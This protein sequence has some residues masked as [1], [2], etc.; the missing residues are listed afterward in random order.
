MRIA[1]TKTPRSGPKKG[2]ISDF[3]TD[4]YRKRLREALKGDPSAAQELLM[5]FAD[6][7]AAGKRPC[8]ETLIYLGVAARRIVLDGWKP[9]KALGLARPPHR[10][11]GQGGDRML[12]LAVQ[13]ERQRRGGKTI[14]DAVATT[15][16]LLGASSRHVE[17]AWSEYKDA[18]ALLTP[19]ELDALSD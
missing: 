16:E 3:D 9:T 2:T 6:A 7:V 17:R 5:V 11:G 1:R 10:P 18:V 4:Y 12:E 19:A 8:R 14:S 15:E 13:V